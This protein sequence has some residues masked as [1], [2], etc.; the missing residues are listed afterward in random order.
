M[1]I[2]IQR[3]NL[4]GFLFN[5]CGLKIM[6]SN[7]GLF[8]V[9]A[10]WLFTFPP[11][12]AAQ[13]WYWGSPVTPGYDRSSVVEISGTVQ[14]ADLSKRWGH[15]SVHVESNGETFTVM[16]GPKWYLRQQRVDIGIGDKLAVK[17]SKMKSRLGKTYLVAARIKNIRTGHVLE[18]RDES[19]H[20]L[21]SS[22]RQSDKEKI[23]EGKP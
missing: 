5:R 1:K 10:L 7:R 8:L 13:G 19:G 11:A 3:K 17:G 2:W 15:T 20:P 18:L 16:L 14:K 22:R 6:N 21:W 23:S 9:L 12:V 4:W